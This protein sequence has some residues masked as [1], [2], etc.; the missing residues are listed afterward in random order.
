VSV[1][2]PVYNGADTV[3]ELVNR[4]D[5]ALIDVEHE[6]LLVNDGSDDP[7][8]DRIKSL[9]DSRQSVRGVDLMRNYGQHNALLAGIRQAQCAVIVTM[10]DDLQHPPEEIGRLLNELDSGYDVVYGLPERIRHARWR[11]LASRLTKQALAKAMGAETATKI[12]SFRAFRT[13]LRD[14]FVTYRGPY[15]SIDAL[16]T[17]STRSFGSVSY[18]HQP[19]K[20]GESNYSP[21]GLIRHALSMITAFST[22]PLQLASI[23]GFASVVFGLLVLAYVLADYFLSSDEVPGFAFLASL[24]TILAGAQM[25]ALGVMGEYL[26]RIHVRAMEQPPYTIR[27]LTPGRAAPHGSSDVAEPLDVEISPATDPAGD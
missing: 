21:L 9:V 20:A 8:W 11:G 17:W 3:D 7:S 23:V 6:I 27:T 10:D 5:A 14:G 18:R 12:D 22:R 2:V 24:I 16:L 26:A 19:R 1:V 13:R 15:V 4:I 25:F